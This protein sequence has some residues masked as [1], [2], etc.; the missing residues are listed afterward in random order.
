MSEKRLLPGMVVRSPEI[1][2]WLSQFKEIDRSTAQSL[3]L[4]LKFI[5]RDTYAKFVLSQLEELTSLEKVGVFAVRK[6]NEGEPIWDDD[7]T[8]QKSSKSQGSEDFVLSIISQAK[9]LHSDV[10]FD[11]PSIC[12]IRLNKI[13]HIILLDDSI[14]SGKRISRYLKNI[15]SNK[16][17]LSWISGGFITIHV[18]SYARTISAE[19]II[20]NN[21]PG[22]K[23]GRG[24]RPLSEKLLFDS[25]LRYDTKEL[26][27]RW[28][29]DYENIEALCNHEKKIPNGI[30]KGYGKV[31]A[32]IVFY[33]SVPNNI[34]G[35]LYYD[36]NSE[37]NPLFPGRVLSDWCER[38][39]E[40]STAESETFSDHTKKQISF[41][42]IQ[43]KR[44]LKTVASLS[45]SIDSDDKITKHLLKIMISN[46]LT[47]TRYTITKSGFDFLR[48][49]QP[50]KNRF[51]YNFS[52]YIPKTWCAGQKETQPSE[53]I[54]ETQGQQTDPI[55][56]TS[57]GG[58]D[59][60]SFLER[61]DAMA[62]PSPMVDM[63]TWSSRSRD[64]HLDYGPSGLKDK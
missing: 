8:G 37:W 53:S 57:V 34:P 54:V 27:R 7:N 25:L 28:G 41:L 17:F 15:T 61:T 36:K 31:M 42:L 22:N 58:E 24:I 56:D 43:L 10:F 11:H 4:H 1:Q 40:G 51:P 62:P 55:E 38:L 48:T 29:D 44:G 12:E 63:T 18:V 30:R 16:T 13:H 5:S 46:G 2:Q 49:Q 32:N 23:H 60:Q 21:F 6:F 45:R 14:G 20:I 3:L 47:T 19:K 64:R 59:G 52:L 39:M 50:I 9:K 33:H 26:Q 35:I